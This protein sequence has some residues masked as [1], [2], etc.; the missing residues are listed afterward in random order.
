[1]QFQGQ[2]KTILPARQGVS[3]RTGNEWKAQP[4]IF[5]YFENPSDRYADS[6]LLETLDE[7]I[8]SQLKEGLKVTIGFG[9]H[10]KDYI[11][12]NGD[13]AGQKQY[14]NECRIYHFQIDAAHNPAP[15]PSGFSP[16]ASQ[17]TSGAPQVQQ[18]ETTGGEKDDLPF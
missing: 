8:I 11:S 2:I 9:H 17:E 10:V 16:A 18:Q 4:F 7:K 3:Q 5:E 1:M 14:L 15:T 13:K 6:V 12:K